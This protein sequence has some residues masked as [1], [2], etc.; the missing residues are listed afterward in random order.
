MAE[1][2]TAGRKTSRHPDQEPVR[3]ILTS[4]GGAAR[5]KARELA[6]LSRA[7]LEEIKKKSLEELFD[8]TKKY[9]RENPGKTLLGALAAGFLL[10]RLLRR[11]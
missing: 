9:I 6:D 4:V 1:A 3:E 5:E 7:K 11:R 8:D 2:E 10:G